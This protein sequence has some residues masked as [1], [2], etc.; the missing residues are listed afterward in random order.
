[1]CSAGSNDSP[2]LR[3][4]W[5]GFGYLVLLGIFVLAL[6]PL[7]APVPIDHG[8]KF[9]HVLAF[10]VLML[11]FAGLV[12]PSRYPLLFTMFLAY[13][14]AMEIAQ[15]FTPNRFMDFADFVADAIG[16]AIGWALARAGLRYWPR[17]IESRLL[18][19]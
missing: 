5:L 6:T 8:D 19:G 1:M 10:M 18:P 7:P 3:N 17:W 2:R 14:G 11:W 4:F 16:A 13:G 12:P 9:T 15:N